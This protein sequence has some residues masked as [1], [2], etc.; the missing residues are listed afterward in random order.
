MNVSPQFMICTIDGDLEVDRC[1]ESGWRVRFPGGEREDV[2]VCEQAVS[3]LTD[4]YVRAAVEAVIE[5]ESRKWKSS[6]RR[7]DPREH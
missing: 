7:A 2:L 3:A 1:A 5:Y 6:E 4:P